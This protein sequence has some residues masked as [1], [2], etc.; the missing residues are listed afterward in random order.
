MTIIIPEDPQVPDSTE[1]D[2]MRINT[3]AF[4][5]ADPISLQLKHR[6][7]MRTDA[8]GYTSS[9]VNAVGTDIFRLI[10]QVDVMTEIQTPDGM[11]LI[12]TY[13]LLGTY[14]CDMRRWDKFTLNN[15]EFII[16]SPVRPDFRTSDYWYE[17][18]ADVARL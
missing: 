15:V 10:A 7:K 18:K 6:Q 16:V 1:L 14:D 13:V 11:Q 17:R 3:K 9:Y 2:F 8:G 4:I 5:D 12:P